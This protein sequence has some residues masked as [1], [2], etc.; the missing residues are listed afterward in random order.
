MFFISFKFTLS[1]SDDSGFL[2]SFYIDFSKWI[3]EEFENQ[4][5][6]HFQ[7]WDLFCKDFQECFFADIYY[8]K[9]FDRDSHFFNYGCYVFLIYVF[10]RNNSG[11]KIRHKKF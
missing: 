1:L 3:K 4:K 10:G 7:F 8:L 9:I 6:R 11:L 2:A 5:Y